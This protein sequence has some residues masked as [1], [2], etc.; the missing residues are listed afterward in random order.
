MEESLEYL[1]EGLPIPTDDGSCNHLIGMSIP[2]IKLKATNGKLIELKNI[3]GRVVFYLYPMTGP[4]HIPLPK[5]W[6]E[7]PG[8]RGCTPQACSFK[9]NYAELQ[10]LGLTVF[11]MSTQSSDFQIKEKER[12]HLPFDLL[13]D[14]N[15]EFA[16]TLNLPLHYVE[17]LTLHKRVTLIFKDGKIVKYFYPVF[18]PD[19][20][21]N[22]VIEWLKA[23]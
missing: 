7:I 1:P 15:I 6:D 23:N 8:A 14:Q 22:E 4:S 10:E 12:I 17:D 16:K 11:G 2:N 9:N 18:P 19:K 20:N 21:I 3:D 13:S 5:G